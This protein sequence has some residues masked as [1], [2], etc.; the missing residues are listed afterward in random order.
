MYLDEDQLPTGSKRSNEAAVLEKIMKCCIQ[1]RVSASVDDF[2][3]FKFLKFKFTYDRLMLDTCLAVA[4]T[5]SN[6]SSVERSFSALRI[7]LSDLRSNLLPKSVEDIMLCHLN[8]SLFLKFNF[9]LI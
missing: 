8:S 4:A 6:Q 9:D 1:H 2:D 5:P 7:L 3:I